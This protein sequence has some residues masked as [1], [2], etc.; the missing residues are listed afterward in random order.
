MK[1]GH[2]K[3]ALQMDLRPC[4]TKEYKDSTRHILEQVEFQRFWAGKQNWR[5]VL[6]TIPKAVERGGDMK[7]WI[8]QIRDK[9][10]G[11]CEMIREG[12]LPNRISV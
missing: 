11:S 9:A 6:Y 12:A 8:D 10:A 3:K 4:Q 2:L 5:P 7:I 1:Q